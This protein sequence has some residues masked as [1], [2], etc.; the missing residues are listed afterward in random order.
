MSKIYTIGYTSTTPEELIN[1]VNSLEA[2]LVDIR[3]NPYSKDYRW[4]QTNLKQLFAD[5]YLHIKE[6]GNENYKIGSIK[7]ANPQG[8]ILKI[9]PII[10]VQPVILLCA[11][12]NHEKC[13]RSQ[14][15]SILCDFFKLEIEHL[16]GKQNSK[17]S[18][19]KL[20]EQLSLF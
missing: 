7:V 10:K 16:Y 13:H 1:L 4:I 14:V 17:S 8:G 19:D 20:G 9:E 12:Y 18:Q 11:C 3:I 5:K 6:F 15:A 2:K